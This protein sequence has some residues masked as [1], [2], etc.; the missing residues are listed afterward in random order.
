MSLINKMLQDLDARGGTRAP[1]AGAD[2]RPVGAAGT[3][4][5]ARTSIAVGAGVGVLIV[6]AG[7]GAWYALNRV[8]AAPVAVVA[9]PAPAAVTPPAPPAPVPVAPAAPQ[10]APPPPASVAEEAAP[11]PAPAVLVP[12]Q[13][14]PAAAGPRADAP[15]APRPARPR[16]PRTEPASAAV[17]VPERAAEVPA[18]QG[19]TLTSR[20]QG[21]NAYRRALAA[22]QVGR[23]NEGIAALEDAVL[24]YPRHEAARQTLVGLLVENGHAEQAMRHAQLGLALEANQPQ[25]AM[26]LARLQ[27]ERGGSADVTLLR[28]LPHAG[29][30]ADYLGFLAAVLQKQGRHADAAAQYEAALRLR[31]DNGVWWMGLG[32][33]RQAENL[34]TPARE[35]F[36]K[37]RDAGLSPELQAFVERRLAQLN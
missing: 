21:E 34:R 12:V 23:V 16:P 22:L 5:T 27:L 4:R 20:Q 37:A 25:L 31:P 8:P 32:I 33:S 17:P 10:P 2:V 29:G 28:T 19:A 9:A 26:V 13:A 7:A 24:V 18:G 6:A 11:A 36:E 14:A 1:A 35:A 15:P 30:N 3:A